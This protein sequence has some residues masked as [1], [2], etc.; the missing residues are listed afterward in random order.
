MYENATGIVL[1]WL[2]RQEKVDIVCVCQTS[3]ERGEF[4][5]MGCIIDL[6]NQVE[7]L[8]L[9]YSYF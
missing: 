6:S 4:V 8:S 2:E 3:E 7:I 5:R 9:L 1:I